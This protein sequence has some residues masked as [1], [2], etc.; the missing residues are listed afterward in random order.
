[1]TCSTAAQRTRSPPQRT[2]LTRTSAVYFPDAVVPEPEVDAGRLAERVLA[3]HAEPLD[4][5]G[6]RAWAAALAILDGRPATKKSQQ[7]R[8]T[9]RG[10]ARAAEPAYRCIPGLCRKAD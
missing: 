10:A 4:K 2:R 3:E 7:R 8:R 9:N 6:R 5:L 1:V